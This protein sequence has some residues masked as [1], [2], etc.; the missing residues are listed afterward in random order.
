MEK[1]QQQQ[2]RMCAVTQNF[3]KPKELRAI[4]LSSLDNIIT[5]CD[6]AP[7]RTNRI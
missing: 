6:N 5:L 4:A 1:K 3:V 7:Y 2:V